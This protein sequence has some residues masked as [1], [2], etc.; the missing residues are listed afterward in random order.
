MLMNSTGIGADARIMT[1]RQ[2]TT[3]K[4]TTEPPRFFFLPRRVVVAPR[5]TKDRD[6]TSTWCDQQQRHAENNKKKNFFGSPPTLRRQIRYS[7]SSVTHHDDDD[8]DDYEIGTAVLVAG[9]TPEGVGLFPGRTDPVVFDALGVV[10]D[11]RRGTYL[12]TCIVCSCHTQRDPS[13]PMATAL[14]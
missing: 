9:W 14:M 10:H 7:I 13:M 3:P 4:M 12:F 8:D 2:G 5:R 1:V 6:N 11:A